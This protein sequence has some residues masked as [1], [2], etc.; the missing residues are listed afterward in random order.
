MGN[1]N[2][3]VINLARSLGRPSRRRLVVT[4]TSLRFDLLH[5]FRSPFEVPLDQVLG[6]GKE[7][8]FK[9]E[10]PNRPPVVPAVF[11][12]MNGERLNLVAA[13]RTPQRIP[14]I[15]T[16][17]GGYFGLSTGR[18][19][20][21]EGVYVDGIAVK[22]A[23][24]DDALRTLAD[25]GVVTTNNIAGAFLEVL[26]TPASPER[27]SEVVGEQRRRTRAG[28]TWIAA[29]FLGVVLVM[30]STFLPE[31]S[32]WFWPLLAVGAVLGATVSFGSW[33]SDRK[34]RHGAPPP[35]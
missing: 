5:I 14:P 21:P 34:D 19:R 1:N 4:P 29:L 23:K 10:V 13:F 27:Q 30:G 2:D 11:I 8:D 22:A 26:G 33:W 35:A 31:E 24:P 6:V 18:S 28:L 9:G 7:A 25:H 15:K 12:A 3:V 16:G 20:S 17:A 32:G